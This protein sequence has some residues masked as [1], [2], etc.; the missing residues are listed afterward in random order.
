MN[1]ENG[2]FTKADADEIESQFP[3]Q[4]SSKLLVFFSIDITVDNKKFFDIRKELLNK[5]GIVVMMYLQFSDVSKRC[6]MDFGQFYMKSTIH[7]I[8]KY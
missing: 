8:R 1:F 6:L 7:N 5:T 4:K 3:S 2:C